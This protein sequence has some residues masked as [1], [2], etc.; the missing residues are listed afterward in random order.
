MRAIGLAEREGRGKMELRLL[1]T[2]CTVA[3]ARGFTRAALQLGYTQSRVTDQTK[4]LKRR[5]YRDRALPAAIAAIR[6][7]DRL[8]P[9]LTP[10]SAQ[11]PET[12]GNHQNR[13]MA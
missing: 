2:F 7:S 12:V 9:L 13:K 1:T 6:Y 11:H 10:L 5:A 8:T 4:T 3:K